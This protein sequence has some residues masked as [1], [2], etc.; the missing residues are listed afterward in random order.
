MG[1]RTQD[2]TWRE[3]VFQAAQEAAGRAQA[4]MALLAAHHVTI[5]GPVN[6]GKSTLLNALA[7]ADRHLVSAVPGTTRD[8][9]DVPAAVRGLSVLLSDTAGLRE[10][11][12]E[13][14]QE[15]Q[16]RAEQAA[17]E[18][19]LRLVVLDGAQPPTERDMK[20]VADSTAAGPTLLVLNKQDLGV[21]ETARGL[22]FLTGRE[23]CGISALTG[24]GLDVLE[25][26]LEALLLGPEQPAPGDPFT[27]RQTSHLRELAGSLA[28]GGPGVMLLGRICR[29]VGTRPDPEGFQAVLEER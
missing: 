11:A 9:L 6:A 7:R 1:L 25:Q 5:A 29:L 2:I 19:E 23:A 28:A 14:E 18:A 27:R 21:D 17:R 15:G 3:T 24:A 4:G 16:R 20:L 8:R 10:T 26:T 12:D 22:G 13:L